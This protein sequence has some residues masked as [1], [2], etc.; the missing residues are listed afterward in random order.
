MRMCISKVSEDEEVLWKF[1]SYEKPL[2]V[3]R[4]NAQSTIY[5]RPMRMRP[6]RPIA[7]EKFSI[8]LGGVDVDPRIFRAN[9]SLRHSLPQVNHAFMI[10]EISS[11]AMMRAWKS[12]LHCVEWGSM[13]SKC[14][15][16]PDLLHLLLFPAAN[17]SRLR[18]VECFTTFLLFRANDSDCTQ[19][20]FDHLTLG[21]SPLW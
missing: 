20:M 3:F 18:D 10:G 15:L 4:E 2:A 19:N 17:G 1:R 12:Q 8:F 16:G 5:T 14:Q 7:S 21:S 6:I 13:T 9:T 11:D